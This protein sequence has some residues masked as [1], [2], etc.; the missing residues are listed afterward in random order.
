MQKKTIFTGSLIALITTFFLLFSTSL[1][2]SSAAVFRG[3]TPTILPEGRDFAS[4]VLKDAWDMS[5]YTDISQY[6]NQSGQADLLENIVVANGVFSARATSLRQASFHL[7]FPGYKNGLLV[8]KV[9]HIYPISAA[10]YKCLYVAAKVDSGPPENGA[11]DQMVVYWFANEELNNGVWGVTSPGIW[12]YPEALSGTP[13]PRWKLFSLRLDQ[14]VTPAGYT[15]WNQAPNGQWQGLRIDASLQQTTFQVDWVR[16][17]DCASVNL[18]IQWPGS[19]SVSVSVQPQGTNRDILMLPN[20]SNNPINLDTEGLEPGTYTYFVRQNNQIITS[21]ELTVEQSPIANFNKPSFTS[22]VDYA[23]EAGHPWD[24]SDP[25]D[26]LSTQCMQTNLVGG[27]LLM[28]TVSVEYQPGS[29]NAGGYSD[30]GVYLS[31]FG[32]AD[33]TQYRYLTFRMYTAGPWQNVPHAMIARWVWY[34]QATTGLP[35]DRCILVSYGVPYDVGWQTYTVDLQD[36]VDG[37][38]EQTSVLYCP[39]GLHWLDTGP[40]L[41]M[42]FDPNENIMGVTMHQELDWIR[43][44]KMDEVVR[45][46]P[47][48]IKVG[49]NVPWSELR[50][51]HLYYTDALQNPY[52][53]PVLIYSP[54]TPTPFSG[55]TV[56]LPFVA[57]D[58]VFVSGSDNVKT[59][60]WETTNVTAGQYYLCIETESGKGSKPIYCSEAPVWVK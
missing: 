28:D 15:P 44:T 5:E 36:P 39:P 46:T 32:P 58:Y 8:G 18:S 4:R 45:G 3:S 51:Y 34:I 38:S 7:L 55:T 2:K 20:T 40:A 25:G 17:T 30:P 16:L 35:D 13:V 23:T 48:T 57:R 60:L 59:F 49:L 56:Y 1:A 24:M 19:G 21:G 12:L 10:T 37:N 50:S 52:Q 22:G 26:V 9:G 31:S 41:E 11:P 54:P 29:C 47:F 43:L 42:R 27:S 33:T 14:A 6:I 53:H